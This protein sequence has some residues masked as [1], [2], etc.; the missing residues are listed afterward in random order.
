MVFNNDKTILDVLQLFE[1]SMSMGKSL[2]YEENCSQ[3]LRLILKRKNLNASWILQENESQVQCSY[4]IPSIDY[5]IQ[6]NEEELL[7]YLHSITSPVTIEVDEIHRKLSPIK[8]ETGYLFIYPLKHEGHLFLYSRY[9]PIDLKEILKLAPVIDKFSNTLKACRAYS[10]QAK[11]LRE[12][13]LR[14]RDLNDYAHVVSHDLKSPLRNIETMVSWIEHDLQDKLPQDSQGFL[15]HI[16]E[17]IVKMERLISDVL[18]YSSIGEDINNRIDIDLNKSLKSMLSYLYVPNHIKVIIKDQLP[19][20]RGE[21]LQIE[22][23]FQNLV[24]NAIK[25]N[26]KEEGRV[27]ISYKDASTHHHFSVLDNGIGIEEKYYDK[28]FHSFHKLHNYQDSSGLGLSIVKRI[29]QKYGGDIKVQSEVG[30]WSEFSFT[31]QKT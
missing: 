22:Q 11:I 2:D 8:I 12:L 31:I 4:A 23:I 20:I 25:Y 3:F 27:E 26:D 6:T 21:A 19:V 15:N 30:K 9:Q 24:N 16:R 13:E 10:S 7:N 18:V 28:I 5:N 17:N 1:Y 29:I 14:N